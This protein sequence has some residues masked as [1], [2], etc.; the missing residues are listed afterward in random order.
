MPIV[1]NMTPCML[2]C[3]YQR[4]AGAYCLH[5]Q[6]SETRLSLTWSRKFTFFWMPWKWRQYTPSKRWYVRTNL[7]G[8][9]P[10]KTRAFITT[11]LGI[12]NLAYTYIGNSIIA[13]T[14]LGKIRKGNAVAFISGFEWLNAVFVLACTNVIMYEMS[15]GLFGFQPR[16]NGM[17]SKHKSNSSSRKTR[18]MLF[19]LWINL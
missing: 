16:F 10:T 19:V 5:F 18:K 9:I 2:V 3:R 8:S 13:W 1:W 6:D 17:H 15:V 11:F 14:V 7:D 12:S 4:F